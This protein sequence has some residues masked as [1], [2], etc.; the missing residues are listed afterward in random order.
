[1]GSKVI[2]DQCAKEIEHEDDLVVT[3]VIFSVTPY[4]NRC[5]VD[6]IKGMSSFFVGNVP[7]NG[8]YSNFTT[9]FSVLCFLILLLIESF[10]FKPLIL[11]AL[12]GFI[13]FRIYSYV[14]YERQVGKS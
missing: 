4:C 9:F 11:L 12:G 5:Y 10:S 14:V 13:A 8:M 1:M 3:T 7:L 6:R 2:C